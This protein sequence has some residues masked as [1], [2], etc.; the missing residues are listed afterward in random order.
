MM[1]PKQTRLSLAESSLA[2]SSLAESSLASVADDPGVG[3]YTLTRF[4]SNHLSRLV[5]ASLEP[6][7][8]FLDDNLIADALLRHPSEVVRRGTA[9]GVALSAVDAAAKART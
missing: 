4:A 3:L 2:E 8:P 7:V 5:A 9:V 6:G 1:R